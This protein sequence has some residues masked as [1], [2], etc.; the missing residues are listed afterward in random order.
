[1]TRTSSRTSFP[2]LGLTEH[3][4]EHRPKRPVLLA[5]DQELGECA[6]LRIAP[7]LYDPVGSLAVGEHQDVEQLGAW[8][9]AERVE[10]RRGTRR[11]PGQGDDAA[12]VKNWEGVL[13]GRRRGG[14]SSPGV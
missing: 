5:V 6:P 11:R 12:T 2:L 8:C 14:R 10:A 4:Y 9:G 3:P 1:M 7:E 13:S